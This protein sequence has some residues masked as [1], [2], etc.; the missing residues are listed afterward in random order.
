M[1]ISVQLFAGLREVMETDL[2]TVELDQGLAS[3]AALRQ[4]L[5]TQYP[6]LK[7]YLSGVAIAVN[8]EYILSDESELSGGD[9]V[10]LV[11]P[12][13]GGSR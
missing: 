9:S 8:E 5:E 7:P 3:V 10:A 13:A 12:I 11:P 4:A 6:K 1:K 2:L